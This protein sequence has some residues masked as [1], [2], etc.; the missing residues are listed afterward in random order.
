HARPHL[1]PY[2]TL[3]RSEFNRLAEAE[4][5][6]ARAERLSHSAGDDVTRAAAQQGIGLVLLMRESY[7]RA[8][9]ALELALRAQERSA[10]RRAAR[11]EEHTSELQSLAYF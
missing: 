2:T 9:A 11:S 5:Q 1:F 7:S 3:F 8:Q 6:Y 4:R 10:D